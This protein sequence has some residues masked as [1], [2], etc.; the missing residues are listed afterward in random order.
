MKSKLLILGLVSWACRGTEVSGGTEVSAGRFTAL[1][2]AAHA[3]E[4]LMAELKNEI[5][6]M[7]EKEQAKIIDQLDVDAEWPFECKHVT[8]GSLFSFTC[9]EKRPDFAYPGTDR[10][11]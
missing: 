7:E 2:K 11:S 9:K 5:K 4:H 8:M 3:A 1:Q 6:E 10:E